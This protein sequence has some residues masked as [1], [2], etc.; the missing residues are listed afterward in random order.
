MSQEAPNQEKQAAEEA[1]RMRAFTMGVGRFCKD[2]GVE[3]DDLA[4]AA[5]VTPDQLAPALAEV[6]VDAAQAQAAQ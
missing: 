6:L 2:A 3:Y 5:G 1:S 4:K